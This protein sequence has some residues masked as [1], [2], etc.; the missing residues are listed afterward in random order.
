MDEAILRATVDLLAGQGY[1]RLT[2]DRVARKA[3]VAKTSLYRRWPTKEALVID[4]IGYARLAER[5]AVPDTGSL[6]GDMLGFLRA[7]VR[8][9]RD[10]SDAIAALTS[11]MLANR[12]L[13]DAF[14]GQ[15]NADRTAGFRT[16]IER[17]VQ[18]GELPASTDVELLVALPFALVHYHRVL[19]G[20]P[21]DE[22]LAKRI[23]DQFFS[24]VGL[25]SHSRASQS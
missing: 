22:A 2:M 14:C 23:A 21:P 8:Y 3:A 24:P 19:T 25:R 5:P 9:R 13:A 12:T 11:E 20:E 17:A 4:A 6:H 18:R 16:I 1:S 10:Q 15:V 7:Q